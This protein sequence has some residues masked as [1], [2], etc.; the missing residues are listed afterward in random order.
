MSKQNYKNHSKFVP[1]FHF[2]IVPLLLFVFIGSI[3]NVFH[4]EPANIYS[5]S[6]LVALSFATLVLAFIVRGS[7]LKVQD[8]AIR[9]EENFRYYLAAGKQQDSRLTML[10]IIALR[11]AGDD[12]YIGLSKK[13]VDENMSAKEIKLA[14]QQ[15]KGDHH[16]A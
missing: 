16:R 14:I 4:S 5:A 2:V 9:A 11:F 8:R 10:Q 13:A 12:E 15:W 3:V 1:A 6:L 7:V